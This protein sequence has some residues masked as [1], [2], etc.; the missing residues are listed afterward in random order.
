MAVSARVR[1]EKFWTHLHF[2]HAFNLNNHSVNLN[3]LSV[4]QKK[5]GFEVLYSLKKQWFALKALEIYNSHS[6]F[7]PESLKNRNN[8]R[9]ILQPTK[10]PGCP[11]WKIPKIHSPRKKNRNSFPAL[12]VGYRDNYLRRLLRAPFRNAI[13]A[14]KE[15]SFALFSYYIY[16]LFF[17]LFIRLLFH[18]SQTARA[19]L[20]RAQILPLINLWSR[21][22]RKAYL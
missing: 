15:L 21:L 16:T 2:S 1:S 3:Y 12:R 20:R 6:I 9:Q 11:K 14:L 17:G 4:Y 8:N 7:I 18:F 5:I 22:W 10:I 19:F 13:L